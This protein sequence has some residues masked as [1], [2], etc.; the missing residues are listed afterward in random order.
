MNFREDVKTRILIGEG[1]MGTL[2]YSHG[3]DHCYE[4]MNSTDPDQIETIH[5]TYAQAGA[6]ILQSN[7]YGANY[8]KLKRY[9]LEDQV[10]S[11]NRKG[12]QIAKKAAQGNHFVFGTIGAMRSFRKSDLELEEIKRSFREQLYSLL[13]E[14][15]DGILLETYYDLQ[16]LETVLQIARKETDLP[17]I[18]NVSLHELGFLQNGMHLQEAFTRLEDLG[19]DVVGVNCRLGPHHMIRALEEVALPKHASIAVYPNA[20]LPD[21]VDGRLVYEAVPAYFGSSAIKLREQ[22]ASIIGGCCGTTPKHI[23]AV[24]Q[25][26]QDLAPVT[27]KKIKA[28]KIEVITGDS[29][30]DLPALHE[31][32]QTK[33]T[34]LVELD[35]PKKLGIDTFMEGVAA[36]K[37]AGVDSVTLADNSLASPRIANVAL[38]VK[39]KNELQVN[40]LIHITCRDRNLIGLQSHLMGLQTLGLQEVLVVTGDP[41]K[42]G[43]FPGATSVFD[44]SSFDLI[45]LVRQFNEGLSYS[46]QSL[47]Q[48]TN[49]KIAAAFNPNVKYLHK[50]VERMEKKIA[51]GAQSFLS[52]PIYSIDQ[53]EEVYEATKHINTPIFIG[54]MPLTST[55]NAEFIHN[56]VPGIKLPDSVRHAMAEA[57]SDPIR[58]RN[59]GIAIA[60]EL[61]DAAQEKFKGIY[62]ITPF[63]RYEMTAELTQYIRQTDSMKNQGVTIHD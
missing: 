30:E 3:I 51:C 35:P 39:M 33:R 29:R 4:E 24:K 37:A 49:F 7:T 17:I 14:D 45:S 20:S 62:L 13:I 21:Y 2:L 53:I 25:A 50:S 19:T 38:G 57:G 47:G 63:L 43:D 46:G 26:I 36:L 41:S 58:A 1:A 56:E 61:V 44:L 55:R 18:A 52:Q 31:Q 32:A 5:R 23:L 11:I 22:G 40:P 59:E 8:Y 10:S 9:G 16:E 27:E 42:I 6:D 54:I 48:R 28:R 60:R 15:P 34:I 12:I